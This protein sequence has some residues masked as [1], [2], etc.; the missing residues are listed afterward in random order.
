MLA[1]VVLGVGYWLNATGQTAKGGDDGGH[2]PP[3]ATAP[4]SPGQGSA[5]PDD[6]KSGERNDQTDKPGET[7]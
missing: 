1:V 4:A 6:G 2:E 5:A 7:K 3:A